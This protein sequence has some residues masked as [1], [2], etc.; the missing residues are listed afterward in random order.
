MH[1]CQ[2]CYGFK[3]YL[4]NLQQIETFNFFKWWCNT[5]QGFVGNLISGERIL[6]IG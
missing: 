2:M 5:L 3:F 6:K 1:F 4:C